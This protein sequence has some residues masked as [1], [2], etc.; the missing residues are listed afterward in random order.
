MVMQFWIT[1][2]I[3]MGLISG[4]LQS[5]EF[6]DVQVNVEIDPYKEFENIP[7]SGTITITHDSN[8][9]VDASS[10]RMGDAPAKVDFVKDVKISPNSPLELSM[11]HFDLP[12]QPAGIYTLPAVS[13]KVGGK[14]YESMPSSYNINPIP[15]GT[16]STPTNTK[17]HA[18]LI[19]KAAVEGPQPIYPGQ[20]V[21]FVYRFYFR[22]DIEL[23]AESLPLFETQDFKIVGDKR[24]NESTENDLDVQEISQEFEAVKP[25][26]YTFPAS[27]IEGYA[28]KTSS[29]KEHIYIQPKL[30]SETPAITVVVTPFPAAGKPLTFNGAVG[31]FTFQSSLITTSTI[32]V[33]DKIILALDISSRTA[34]LST[35]SLPDLSHSEL[36]ALFRFSDLPPTSKI[37]DNTK[38]FLV[39]L[40]PLSNAIKEIPAIPFSYFDPEVS[41]YVTLN[42]QPIPITI[43]S[44]KTTTAP[45]PPPTQPV[46][47]KPSQ[48]TAS[49]AQ[50]P[51]IEI[52][53]NYSLDVFDLRNKPFGEWWVLW[54]IPIGIALLF[55][56]VWLSNYMIKHPRTN[57]QLRSKD[58][59]E[60]A[61]KADPHSSEF[62]EL[63]TKSLMLKLV[64]ANLISSTD[65]PS[66]KLSTTGVVGEVR[67]FITSL[68]AIRFTGQKDYSAD[69]LTKQAKELFSKINK[70]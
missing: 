68:E 64:E 31:D 44:T 62:F 52:K 61:L 54:F 13:V 34:Q 49:P 41:K 50:L 12:A 46:P 56:Q 6:D 69:Q 57:P 53:K 20:L 55:L 51:Q 28:Y 65:L 37:T 15:A 2:I 18:I 22:D 63:L 5:N 33:G 29:M 4:Q 7:L 39:E 59:F 9:K 19:L 35:I 11:Y 26:T 25:G 43:K 38:R 3:G 47:Q 27:Y 42:S 45:T 17:P 23:T 58:L 66:E 10:F 40:Y 24:T 48:V 16:T 36:S 67:A 30:R 32:N 14:V 1:L 60:N 8:T 21:T 70:T